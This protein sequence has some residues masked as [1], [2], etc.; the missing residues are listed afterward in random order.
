MHYTSWMHNTDSRLCCHIETVLSRLSI[1]FLGGELKPSLIALY[2][3]VSWLMGNRVTVTGKLWVLLAWSSSQ[4]VISAQ[5]CAHS[6][7]TMIVAC[8]VRCSP[9]QLPPF[10]LPGW[11]TGEP[12]LVPPSP[13]I[14]PPSHLNSYHVLRTKTQRRSHCHAA[15]P[16]CKYK[17]YAKHPGT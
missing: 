7:S 3:L 16:C 11:P 17:Y 8:G 10:L 4:S 13:F 6:P 14:L 9:S 5:S 15:T 2:F 1:W 12:L